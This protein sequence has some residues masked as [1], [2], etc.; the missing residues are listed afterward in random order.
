MSETRG[1][2]HH[3]DLRRALV[4]AAWAIAVEEGPD[5]VSLRAVARRAGVSH[6]APYHHY[7]D[8]AAL[9]E[10]VAV[11]GLDRLEV[12]LRDAHENGPGDA[13]ER[14]AGVGAAYVRFVRANANAFHL[15]TQ[16]ELRHGEVAEAANRC[17]EVLN[18]AVG[19]AQ[20]EGFIMPGD[21]S[22]WAILAWSGVHGLSMLFIDGLLDPGDD[23]DANRMSEGML[24]AMAHGML[25]RETPP[26]PF[27]ESS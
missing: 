20:D 3:G 12:V 15:M 22:D 26:K 14:F 19:E 9:L 25:M 18:R 11:E 21:P 1:G 13:M 17:L 6:A 5:A 4:E 24:M 7:P 10:A 16:R 23:D 27:F 2:Y 8:K